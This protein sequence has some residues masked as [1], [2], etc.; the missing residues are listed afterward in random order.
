M[1]AKKKTDDK[2]MPDDAAMPVKFTKTDN[3]LSLM[4]FVVLFAGLV[5]V[6]DFFD[7]GFFD[8]AGP[9]AALIIFGLG[10]FALVIEG[11]QTDCVP[12][13]PR[14]TSIPRQP[15]PLVFWIS[16]AIYALGG[17]TMIIVGLLITFGPLKGLD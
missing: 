17:I 6:L 16:L 2:N 9:G 10:L 12:T 11:L 7:V 8:G 4:G 3:L 5:I 14:F 1:S 15:F 13:F